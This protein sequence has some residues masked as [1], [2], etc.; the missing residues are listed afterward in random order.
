MYL[1]YSMYSMYSMYSVYLVSVFSLVNTLTKLNVFSVFSLFSVF[2]EFIQCIQCIYTAQYLYRSPLVQYICICLLLK[3]HTE[4]CMPIL[5]IY[6]TIIQQ[7][8]INLFYFM[9]FIQ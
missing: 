2:S 3:L 9:E 4:V 8:K 5:Y 7:I 1:V 6:L